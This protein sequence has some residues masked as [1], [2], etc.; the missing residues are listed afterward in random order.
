MGRLFF[1]IRGILKKESE[2][3]LFMEYLESKNLQFG[4]SWL[5]KE[6]KGVISH[7]NDFHCNSGHQEDV[8]SFFKWNNRKCQIS[9][10]AYQYKDYPIWEMECHV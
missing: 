8:L 4:G 7:A 2:L 5:N 9:K 10:L 1:Q 6:I 3:D